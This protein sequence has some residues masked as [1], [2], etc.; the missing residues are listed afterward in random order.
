VTNEKKEAEARAHALRATLEPLKDVDWRTLMAAA[1]GNDAKSIIAM[2]F[3]DLAENSSR[4]GE[5]NITPELLS[6]LLKPTKG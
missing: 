5:L 4:I 6:S 1:G 2:A 3:R